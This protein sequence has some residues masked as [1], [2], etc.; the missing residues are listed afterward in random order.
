[1]TISPEFNSEKL[2]A[3]AL[4]LISY[5]GS[6]DIHLHQENPKNQR[7]SF[8]ELNLTT[9]LQAD[10]LARGLDPVVENVGHPR[11]VFIH[12]GSLSEHMGCSVQTARNH[13]EDL[14]SA[15]LIKH[16]GDITADVGNVNLY[17]PTLDDP[18]DYVTEVHEFI[19]HDSPPK[20]DDRIEVTPGDFHH[21][22]DGE[23]QYD[24][25]ESIVIDAKQIEGKSNREYLR[26]QLKQH[27]LIASSIKNFQYQLRD[28]AG[29]T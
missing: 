21:I 23:W 20:Q 2:R 18:E 3:L 5:Y 29:L 25:S 28:G 10:I 8:Q 13:L 17:R 1:M 27:G 4:V 24:K 14:N 12:A 7:D 26:D 15:G 22:G 19:N 9:G 11:E 6:N 16:H